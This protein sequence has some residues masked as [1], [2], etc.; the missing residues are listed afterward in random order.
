MSNSTI[1]IQTVT[2]C[3]TGRLADLIPAQFK[4]N[5]RWI[6]AAP[7][8]CMSDINVIDHTGAAVPENLLASTLGGATVD[9]AFTLR[10]WKF[11]RDATW[12]F[13]LDVKQ[14]VVLRP[15]QTEIAPPFPLY[16]PITPPRSNTTYYSPTPMTPSNTAGTHSGFIYASFPNYNH[17]VF[18]Y[19]HNDQVVKWFS[20][21]SCTCS[22]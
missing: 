11:G 10:G 8:I 2:Q 18:N 7:T 20:G 1:Y 4:T 19:T 13:A 6:E 9:V 22:Q 21:G 5:T 14:I 3:C 15:E 16:N 17:R 12:G